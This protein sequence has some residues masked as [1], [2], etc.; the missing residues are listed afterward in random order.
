MPLR[1]VQVP[2]FPVDRF[3]PYIG[4]ERF[5]AFEA[6]AVATVRHLGEATVWNLNST[7]SGGGVS[8]MLHTLLAYARGARIDARWL[9]IEGEERFFALTKR[10]HHL[11]HGSD[12]EHPPEEDDHAVFAEV[13]RRNAEELRELLRP[14]DV[15][16]LHDPQ[17]AGLAKELADTDVAVVWRCHVG[18]DVENELTHRA[19]SF[20]QPYLAPAAA[21][22]FSRRAYVPREIALD[23]VVIIPPSI[24]PFSAKNQD[25]DHE[26][27]KAIVTHI[28]L[29]EPHGEGIARYVRQD[30]SPGRVD[31]HARILQDDPVPPGAP[32]VVQVSRWDPLKDMLGVMQGFAEGLDDHEDAHLALVG[33]DP[34]GVTDDPEGATVAESCAAAWWDLPAAVRR[35]IHLVNLPMADLEENAAM[36]NAVQRYATIVAQKSLAEGFGLTVTEGMWKAR[37]VVAGHTGGIIDQIAHGAHGLLVDPHD[38]DGFAGALSRLLDDPRWAETLG[39]NAQER[40]RERFL[41]DRHLMDYAELLQTVRA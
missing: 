39:R 13:A 15:V 35:R 27:V 22:V 36:V 1:E 14:G 9:V 19:W 40:V 25:L 38:L 41:S 21:Y 23:P 32:L 4:A 18:A 17:T 3:L 16:I 20:L 30:G 29:V 24:D 10:L 12:P 5:D 11:L 28:G 6:R 37:P 2:A 26:T 34:S 31:R 33:P 8:E 7:A